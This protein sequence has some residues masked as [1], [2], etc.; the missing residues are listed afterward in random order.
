MRKEE[1]GELP[2]AGWTKDPDDGFLC[3]LST[4]RVLDMFGNCCDYRRCK[5]YHVDDQGRV[6]D[7]CILWPDHKG[8]CHGSHCYSYKPYRYLGEDD[9]AKAQGQIQ[10]ELDG[11]RRTFRRV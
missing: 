4:R 1:V 9:V 11:G 10:I 7:R 8:S 6:R 3:L 2:D 5:K